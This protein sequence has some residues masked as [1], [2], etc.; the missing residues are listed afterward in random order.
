MP[1]H[2]MRQER[3]LPG[4]VTEG[5]ST[6]AFIKEGLE[7]LLREI[8]GT[9]GQVIETVGVDPSG[10]DV[11]PPRQMA[12]ADGSEVGQFPG[13]VTLFPGRTATD[14]VTGLGIRVLREG[15]RKAA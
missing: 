12:V 5:P 10:V 2:S 11:L 7:G 13:N 9:S 1:E 6:D 14:S 15:K 4:G 3:T 8:A